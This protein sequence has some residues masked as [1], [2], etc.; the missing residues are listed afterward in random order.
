VTGKFLKDDGTWATIGGSGTVT[1]FSA[2]DLSPLFTT[3]ETN[4]TTT[5]A[6]SF[7]LSNAAAH[8][9]FGNNTGSSAA[10]A[11]SAINE[12]DV[13]SLTTD[14]SNKQAITTAATGLTAAGTNQSTALALSGNNST[15][16]VTTAAS[17]T[18]VKAPYGFG[19]LSSNDHQPGR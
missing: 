17:G 8:T 2:G 1:N 7:T 10:P 4:T 14:L 13:T 12:A 15:Q 6:L 11:F 5:P 9:F 16:E 19:Y 18:G 3:T